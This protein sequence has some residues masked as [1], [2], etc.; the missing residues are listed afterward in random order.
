MRCLA[1]KF[2]RAVEYSQPAQ[3]SFT[4]L[5]KSNKTAISNSFRLYKKKYNSKLKI[6]YLGG[7]FLDAFGTLP[8]T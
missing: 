6:Y 4:P 2:P 1:I 5:Q 7:P 3:L 8:G